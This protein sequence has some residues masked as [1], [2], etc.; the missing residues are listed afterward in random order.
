[1]SWFLKMN[2][3]YFVLCT[4]E[5]R[6]RPFP[7]Q[8][9][10]ASYPYSAYFSGCGCGAGGGQSWWG[11]YHLITMSFFC[12]KVRYLFSTGRW[13]GV[14]S[15]D[16]RTGPTFTFWI[17]LPTYITL[18]IPSSSFTKLL[19]FHKICVIWWKPYLFP[20]SGSGGYIFNCVRDV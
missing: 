8:N 9:K 14:S 18:F 10:K 7:L 20:G 19:I 6:Y 13:E 12:Q 17:I 16:L 11:W 1:M 5:L 15:S 2:L 4:V 3:I